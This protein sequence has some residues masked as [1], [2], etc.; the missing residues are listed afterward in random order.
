[1][2]AIAQALAAKN[3]TTLQDVAA[4]Y[5][6]VF[7]KL[8]EQLKPERWHANAKQP[9]DIKPTQRV[10]P[11]AG[12]ETLRSH[13]FG[14]ASP[15]RP[16]D[17]ILIRSQFLFPRN[18]QAILLQVVSLDLTHPGAPVKAMAL[19]DKAVIKNSPVFI[20]GEPD[21]L[22]PVVPRR[23]L[24]MLAGENA[25]SFTDGSGRL[26]VARAI[27]R[28]DNP[29]AGRL[30]VKRAWQWRVSQPVRST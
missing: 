21:N 16:D 26:E 15:V 3:P 5:T 19:T 4:V 22:G 23:F 14:S 29:L 25:T 8:H 7:A 28:R 10:L 9:F 17:E 13:L 27:A 18:K 30:L 12:L 20:R 6:D 24:S 1:N 11:D 2:P